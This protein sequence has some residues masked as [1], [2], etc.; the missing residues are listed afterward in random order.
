MLKSGVL[1]LSTLPLL[2]HALELLLFFLPRQVTLQILSVS[3]P[4]AQLVLM[5]LTRKNAVSLYPQH[6]VLHPEDILIPHHIMQLD[7][8][9]VALQCIHV[10]C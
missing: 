7:A 6:A 4:I 9:Q 1:P 10:Q 2:E 8:L 3:Q 5:L